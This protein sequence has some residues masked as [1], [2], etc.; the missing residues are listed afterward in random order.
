M[1]ADLMGKDDFT[2]GVLGFHR[3]QIREAMQIGHLLVL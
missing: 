2:M 1:P 3:D